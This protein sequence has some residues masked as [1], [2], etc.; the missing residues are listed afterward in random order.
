VDD[1]G[2]PTSHLTLPDGVPVFDRDGERVGVVDRVLYDDATDI[3]EG[4]IV[5]TRVI[6]GG[7]VLA[8]A[9]QIAELHERGV[10]LA[11]GRDELHEL[12]ASAGRPR[13][14][15][16]SPESSLETALRKAWDWISGRR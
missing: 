3:F 9:D 4:V 16:G 13:H 2:P 5:R 8:A 15:D 7:H 12:D 10:R 1:L 6:P 11:V 14:D